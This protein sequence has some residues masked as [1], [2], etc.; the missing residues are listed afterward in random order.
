IRG[1]GVKSCTCG[2][3]VHRK[4][5][6]LHWD[7]PVYFD[8]LSWLRHRLSPTISVTVVPEDSLGWFAGAFRATDHEEYRDERGLS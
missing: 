4:R 8:F 6:S 2:R 3:H 5:D 1:V 7:L